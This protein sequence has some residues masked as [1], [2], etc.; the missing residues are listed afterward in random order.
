MWA[1]QGWRKLTAKVRVEKLM[2]L[3]PTWE[4]TGNKV[5]GGSEVALTREWNANG[6]SREKSCEKKSTCNKWT[7]QVIVRN[8]NLYIYK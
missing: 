4:N 3:K 5:R 1:E 7:G 6:L 8:I 2:S